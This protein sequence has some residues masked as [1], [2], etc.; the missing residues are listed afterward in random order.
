MAS[1]FEIGSRKQVSIEIYD[2]VISAN[3]TITPSAFDN[4]RHRI[5]RSSSL[6]V[7]TIKWFLNSALDPNSLILEILKLNEAKFIITASEENCVK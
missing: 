4:S 2:I 7:N 1:T 6:E 5:R 3:G